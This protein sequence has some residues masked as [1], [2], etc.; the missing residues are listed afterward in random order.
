[1]RIDGNENMEQ[2]EYGCFFCRTGSELQVAREIERVLPMAAAL[3]PTKLRTRRIDGKPIEEKVTLFPGYVFARMI[4]DSHVYDLP[5]Q[6]QI[7]RILTDSEG[8]WKLK[9]S[10]RAFAEGLFQCVGVLGFSEAYYDVNDRI[11]VIEGPLADYNGQIL[12]VNRR[13]KTAEVQICFQGISMK[14]WL[15]FELIEMNPC[16]E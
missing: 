2:P 13:N 14:V 12:R 16:Q 4:S 8:D 7:L 10:D 6:R 3:V 15:G 9:G 5:Q 1:M 11:H